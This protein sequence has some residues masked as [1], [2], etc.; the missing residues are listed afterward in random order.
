LENST[1]EIINHIKELTSLDKMYQQFRIIDPLNKKVL[2]NGT[3][4]AIKESKCYEMWSNNRMCEN[5]IS[6][7]AFNEDTTFI[8]LEYLNE[9]VFMITA[10]PTEINNKKV[11]IEL[12][13]DVTNSMVVDNGNHDKNV[14]IINVI[15][16]AN[17]V[18]VTDGLTN[19]YNKR[20]ILEN[21]PI[22]INV[23][24]VE[25][26]PLSII[27][28]DLDNFK[29][30][31]DKYG[32]MAG[33]FI[34]K[35]IAYILESDIRRDKDWVSRFGGEEFLVCLPDTGRET[36]L[37]VAE[38]MRKKI[39]TRNFEYKDQKISLTAS[40]GV[41]S[42]GNNSGQDMEMFIHFADMQL[43]KAKKCGK[44]QVKG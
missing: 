14:Q 40:F 8:K 24:K 20:Y 37:K 25:K 21:F 31:N 3:G 1:D 34:L 35:E 39:E 15:N 23:H 9:K 36:A 38:R 28:T 13:K 6:M 5:C 10:I 4:V 7:R 44:N 17:R 33:D 32:H 2:M 42:L 22:E 12:L 30:I 27:M 43:Y 26:R 18:A 19:V 29:I 16:Q 11:V 41:H